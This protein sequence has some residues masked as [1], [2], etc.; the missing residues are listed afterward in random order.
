MFPLGGST[1]G[2]FLESH[3]WWMGSLAALSFLIYTLLSI[4]RSLDRRFYRVAALWGFGGLSIF[5]LLWV[6]A[7]GGGLAGPSLAA[8]GGVLSTA[9]W[10]LNYRRAREEG[11]GY[12]ARWILTGL[13][14]GPLVWSAWYFPARWGGGS[15]VEEAIA[16]ASLSTIPLGVAIARMPLRPFEMEATPRWGPMGWF[17]CLL[18]AVL[19]VIGPSVPVSLMLVFLG[20]LLLESRENARLD[21]AKASMASSVAHDLR[22]PLTGVKLHVQMMRET[23]RMSLERREW[24]LE[25]IEGEV[26]RMTRRVTGALS[27][28]SVERGPRTDPSIPSDLGDLVKR[29]LRGM[30]LPSR[31]GRS[32]LKADFCEGALPFAGDPDAVISAVEEVVANALKFSGGKLVLVETLRKP[33]LVGVRVTDRGLGIASEERERVFEP[34]NRSSRP[35]VLAVEGTGLGLSLVKDT[36]DSHGGHLEIVSDLSQGTRLTLWFPRKAKG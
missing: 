17:A 20:L 34:F 19:G 10:V 33:G 35:E 7:G 21:R 5:A 11:E 16:V 24:H 14:T 3:A 4:R 26:D 31:K 12:Q 1:L 22:T 32:R 28:P 13:L 23:P 36:M 2:R 6:R 15:L 30:E 8:Y 25:V 18:G 27:R 9:L 29:S